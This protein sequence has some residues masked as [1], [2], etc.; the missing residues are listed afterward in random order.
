MFTLLHKEKYT[1]QVH[2][3]QSHF[4]MVN[5]KMKLICESYEQ[6]TQKELGVMPM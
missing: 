1:I 5:K 3:L 6:Q 2:I 4:S